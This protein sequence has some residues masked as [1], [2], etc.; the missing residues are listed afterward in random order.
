MLL[1]ETF[2][3]YCHNRTKHTNTL[4]EQNS[5]FR[6]V[7]EGGTYS[8]HWVLRGVKVQKD[9]G[10]NNKMV[11]KYGKYIYSNTEFDNVNTQLRN[12]L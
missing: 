8:N 5:E 7:K 11:R 9:S 1:R 4:C 2:A 6:Y 12:I 3:V 10:P